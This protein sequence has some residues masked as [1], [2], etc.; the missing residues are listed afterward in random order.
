MEKL[1]IKKDDARVD[2][3]V[4]DQQ[5]VTIGRDSESDLQLN[6]PSVSR[7]HA[8]IQRIYTDLYVEDLGSTNGTSLNGRNITKHVL[9]AGDRLVIGS[10][11]IGLVQEAE[12][13]EDDLDKTVV[14]QPE[15]V[16][17]ARAHKATAPT[18]KLQ[19][20]VATLRFFRGPNKGSTEK[21]DRSLFTIGKPGENVAVIA[22]RPQGF[23]LLHIGGSTFPRI[24]NEEIDSKGGV[25]L[26]E[27]DVV[28]VGDYMAE[29]SFAS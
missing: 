24:N 21:I 2:E 6:D 26:Q 13:A 11:V 4:I 10:F 9:K 5:R 19:P 22:R 8:R 29:I 23:Y 27:G 25:Q 14:I 28:E 16:A 17:A 12:E 3:F 7:Q 15:A 20:K 1:V 18:R